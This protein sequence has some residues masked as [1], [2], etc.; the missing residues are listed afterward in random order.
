[1]GYTVGH[2]IVMLFVRDGTRFISASEMSLA[3]LLY[4]HIYP[5]QH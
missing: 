4:C 2:L 1:M 3:M 5:M